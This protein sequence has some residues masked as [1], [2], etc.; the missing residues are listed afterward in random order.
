MPESSLALI[1]V[2][3]DFAPDSAKV[4][5]AKG[6]LRSSYRADTIEPIVDDGK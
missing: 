3:P 6:G 4:A 1:P 5:G 2:N